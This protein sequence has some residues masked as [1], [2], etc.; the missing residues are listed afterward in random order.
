M[1]MIEERIEQD[2]SR[3]PEPP[4]LDTLRRRLARRRARHG[5]VAGVAL[6]S[7]GAVG[8]V[9]AS[10]RD[11]TSRVRTIPSTAASPTT[12]GALATE[13]VDAFVL[14]DRGGEL[15]ASDPRTGRDVFTVPCDSCA[16]SAFVVDGGTIVDD[17]DVVHLL[18]AD[19]TL[20]PLGAGYRAFPGVDGRAFY[21]VQQGERTIEQ[22]DTTGRRLGGP[23]DVPEK[24]ELSG[25]VFGVAGRAVANGV[26]V[27]TTE[28]DSDHALAVWSPVTG[29]IDVIGQNRWG[30]IDTYTAPG[31]S[32][33]VVAWIRA[34]CATPG[35]DIVLTDT[36]S[37]ESRTVRAPDGFHGFF[38]GG[39][40]SPD[41]RLLAAFPSTVP[42]PVDPGVG[43]AVVDVADATVSVVRDVHLGTGEPYALVGWSP[44]GDWLFFSN[45][46]T[47]Y[48]HRRGTADAVQLDM[49]FGEYATWFGVAARD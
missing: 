9:A 37:G 11:D 22:W 2:L 31:A 28:N 29:T 27:Q 12:R 18:H 26:V 5:I 42:A 33:S 25:R 32:T 46:S 43:V 49:D 36:A 20:Q 14:W 10:T 21:V 38:Y 15:V 48:I 40:F 16:G 47:P 44:S 19:G 30:V 45:H 6:V 7:V 34:G 4:A 3:V 39:A 23:W 17:G 41:G 8:A 24:Y 35:C 1:T 13:R